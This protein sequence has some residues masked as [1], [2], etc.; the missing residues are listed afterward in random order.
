MAQNI[1]V[2]RRDRSVQPRRFQDLILSRAQYGPP[3]VIVGWLLLLLYM[4]VDILSGAPASGNFIGFAIGL[5]VTGFAIATL[6]TLEKI[7][8]T[9][10]RILMYQAA[11]ATPPP[12]RSKPP[13][14]SPA[15]NK[16]VT[17]AGR[18]EIEGRRY[19]AFTDGTVI[20]ETKFGRRR[21]GSIKDAQEFIGA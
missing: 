15:V 12:S 17:I 18:G 4:L 1:D 6:A 9:L 8:T 13:K 16:K 14:A 7:Q 2:L 20:V 10:G 3:L 5:I 19:V 11:A 21:F